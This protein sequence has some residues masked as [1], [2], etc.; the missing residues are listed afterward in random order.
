MSRKAVQEYLSGRDITSPIPFTVGLNCTPRCVRV[1][2]FSPFPRPSSPPIFDHLSK[3]GGGEGLGTR[4]PDWIRV[5][6]LEVV[7]AVNKCIPS[8][9]SDGPEH[10]EIIVTM[11]LLTPTMALR[12]RTSCLN[13]A[14]CREKSR[15]QP[16][17]AQSLL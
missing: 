11:P 5:Q 13:T 7:F 3:T 14:S 16:S 9:Y 12:P 4:L 1:P 15:K 10:L 8:L 6:M 17:Q 2:E